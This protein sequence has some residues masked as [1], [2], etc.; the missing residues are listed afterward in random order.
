MT[1]GW[2]RTGTERGLDRT[3]GLTDGHWTS[4]DSTTLTTGEGG[5]SH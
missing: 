4:Q 2:K 1:P 5:D 3:L